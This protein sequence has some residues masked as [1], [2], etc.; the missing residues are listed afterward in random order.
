[1]KYS[2][3]GAG[4]ISI[5]LL[6]GCN[7][8]DLSNTEAVKSDTTISAVSLDVNH[9]LV[10]NQVISKQGNHW[11]KT[12]VLQAKN[13]GWSGETVS[14]NSNQAIIADAHNQNVKIFSLNT[15]S[16][17]W[18][19][20][21]DLYEPNLYGFGESVYID[22]KIALVGAPFS[23]QVISYKNMNGYWEET[24]RVSPNLADNAYFGGS[25][26]FQQGYLFVGAKTIDKVFIYKQ[27]TEGFELIQT[28]DHF[29]A[30]AFGGKQFGWSLDAQNDQLAI[31]A[32]RDWSNPEQTRQGGKVHIYKKEGATWQWT[33][34]VTAFELDESNGDVI[35]VD[36][37]NF[38]H[39]LALNDTNLLVGDDGMEQVFQF[40]LSENEIWQA[41]RVILPMS[42]R[43]EKFGYFLDI[44]Q[45][46]LL[47]GG[48]SPTLFGPQVPKATV[49]GKVV[50]ANGFPIT[51]AKISGFLNDLYTDENGQFTTQ[52]AISWQGS[53]LASSD[54]ITSNDIEITRLLDDTLLEEIQLEVVP[55]HLI[56]GV[57]SGL[58]R[59]ANINVS[60]SGIDEP[61]STRAGRFSINLPNGWQGEI[62][63]TSDIYKFEP[64]S[65]SINGL[66][67]YQSIRFQTSTIE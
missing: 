13:S 25:I 7:L 10:G 21:A 61:V 17:E 8:N 37:Y 46:F 24:E 1:M 18:E 29:D 58:P 20:S 42:E 49:E 64:S 54:A 16:K 28:I 62:S 26:D 12:Q 2:N 35:N 9:G 34:A 67:D 59:T 32:Y 39:N 52:Q 43:E 31:A 30:G 15:Y 63:P 41:A 50:D 56:I 3:L 40:K 38:G 4:L 66:S 19:Q 57:I 14:I 48:S 5:S 23:N 11:V 44:N 36:G 53:I 51:R 60:V 55:Q 47:A 6:S 22:N 45:N 65:I 27:E 33:Q